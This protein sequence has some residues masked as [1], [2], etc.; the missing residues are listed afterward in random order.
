MGQEEQINYWISS[1]QE[2]WGVVHDLYKSGRYMYAL[3]F[4]HL[5]IEKILKGHWIKTN[6]EIPPRTHDLIYLHDQ[7]ELNLE[8]NDLEL[9]ESMNS[10]NLEGRYPD[11][12]KS[13]YKVAT[14]EFTKLKIERI[15]ILRKWL[16]E[17]LQ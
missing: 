4:V 9:L 11:Y 10:W 16:L 7:T 6:N 3:F 5:T 13:R 2:D 14:A 8:S 15:E 12:K 1:A 17:K